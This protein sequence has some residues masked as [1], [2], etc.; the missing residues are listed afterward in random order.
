[1]LK[2]EKKF[3]II[4]VTA[5]R[6]D[7][8]IKLAGTKPTSRLEIAGAWNSMVTHRVRVTKAS[9]LDAPLLSWL[10]QAYERA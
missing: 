4:Q 2:G 6:I 5:D 9:Q 10:R 3:A 8:G 7:I 1:V